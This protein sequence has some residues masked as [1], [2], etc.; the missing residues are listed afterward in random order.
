[1]KLTIANYHRHL[2][3]LPTRRSSDLRTSFVDESVEMGKLPWQYNPL[4]E[5]PFANNRTESDFYRLNGEIN[6]KI[7]S[8]INAELLYQYSNTDRKSTRL[9]SSHVKISYAVFCLK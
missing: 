9:N 2:Y 1:Y 4:E 5:V 8:Q 6:Y 3:F 7:N